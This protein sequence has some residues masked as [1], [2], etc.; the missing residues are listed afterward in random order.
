[1]ADFEL[2]GT[3]TR[4]VAQTN[5]LWRAD[6][7]QGT[8]HVFATTTARDAIPAATWRTGEVCIIAAD[9]SKWKWNGSAWVTY[10]GFAGGGGMGFRYTFSTLT[11]D[12]DHGNGTVALSSAS[13]ATAGTFTIYPDLLEYGGT[14][15][16]AWLDSFDDYAGAIKGVLRL[17]SLSDPTKWVEYTITAWTTATGYRKLTGAYKDG[18]GG[19]T[20]T[21][22]DTFVS[23]DFATSITGGTSITVSAAGAVTRAAL[24]GDVTASADSNVT[25]IANAAVTNAKLASNAVT[26]AKVDPAAAI[27]CTKTDGNF[28][29]GVVQTTGSFQTTGFIGVG[30]GTRAALGDVRA[31]SAFSIWFHSPSASTDGVV[32]AVDDSTH[33]VSI[34]PSNVAGIGSYI[35]LNASTLELRVGTNATSTIDVA[36]A[37]LNINNSR[38]SFAPGV[39]GAAFMQEN[40]DSAGITCQKLVVRAQSSAGL[41]SIG[42]D[43]DFVP[44]SGPSRGG[45]GRLVSGS[46]S[47]GSGS[48]RLSWDDTGMSFFTAATLAQAARVGQLTDSSGGSAGSTVA[49]AGAAYSQTGENDFRATVAA[50][51]NALELLIHNVGLSA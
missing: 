19:L 11:T 2:L 47:V 50:K 15:V 20:T 24:T 13:Y 42:G 38:W 21:A 4:N 46:T 8:V 44:G 14:D 18:P 9:D 12:A 37:V 1:M 10:T 40:N 7:I 22:G 27:Q 17:Q 30:A 6:D 48:A 49:A 34:G 29:S 3:G 43:I 45:K 31:S 5:P 32:I 35:Y 39:S 33:R 41:T 36:K 16:T 23:F 28:G 51:I 25:T 26:D